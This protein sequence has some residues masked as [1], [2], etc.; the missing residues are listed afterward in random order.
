MRESQVD[1][2]VLTAI[3]LEYDAVRKVH[4]GAVESSM[5]EE[6]VGPANLLVSLRDFKAR[7]GGVLRVAVTYALEMG[8]VAA[9]NAAAPLMREYNP[10]CIA[11]SGV[12]AGRRGKVELGDVLI[13]DQLWQYDAGKRVAELDDRGQSTE[14]FFA[15]TLTYQLDPG[16]KQRAEAFQ[17]PRNSHWLQERP[18][19]V[20]SQADWILERLRRGENPKQHPER[21]EKC[22]HPDAAM[23]RLWAKGLLLPNTLELTAAGRERAEKLDSQHWSGLPNQPQFKVHVGPIGTGTQVVEDPGIFGRLST[24]MRDVLG[25]E[26]EAAAIGAVAHQHGM[27]HLVMKGVMDFAD[28]DKDDQFK[29]FAA[30]ASAECLLAFL[31]E[32]LQEERRDDFLRRLLERA[33]RASDAGD[34]AEAERLSRQA[35]DLVSATTTPE[36]AWEAWQT[37]WIVASDLALMGSGDVQ[38]LEHLLGHLEEIADRHPENYRVQVAT[39]MHRAAW[40]M[41]SGQFPIAD[42]ALEHARRLADESGSADLRELALIQSGR[43]YARSHLVDKLRD[44]I[45]SGESIRTKVGPWADLDASLAMMSGEPERAETAFWKAIR[46]TS[47]GRLVYEAYTHRCNAA[48]YM[49]GRRMHDRAVQ[50]CEF[51][52]E[53]GRL[54]SDHQLSIRLSLA[55]AVSRLAIGNST[56]A[57]TIFL[58]I[59]EQTQS[60][61]PYFHGMAQFGLADISIDRGGLAAARERAA[62]ARRALLAANAVD[63][64]ARVTGLMAYSW[65]SESPATAEDVYDEAIRLAESMGHPGRRLAASLRVDLVS[66]AQFASRDSEE[67]VKLVDEA[68]RLEELA[69]TEIERLE[70][71][72]RI[73]VASS[74]VAR[75]IRAFAET[76]EGLRPADSADLSGEV[77]RRLDPLLTWA[78]CYPATPIPEAL[79][80]AWGRGSFSALVADLRHDSLATKFT[81]GVASAEEVRRAVRML[82]P[83]ADCLVLIWRGA[84]DSRFEGNLWVPAPWLEV[85]G[86]PSGHGYGIWRD[87]DTDASEEV[88]KVSAKTVGPDGI[89]APY[90][91]VDGG[92]LRRVSPLSSARDIG[93][94]AAQGR[95]ASYGEDEV[96]W[97]RAGGYG[98]Y[99]PRDVAE[100]FLVELRP[101]VEIGRVILLPGDLVGCPAVDHDFFERSFHAVIG[102]CAVDGVSAT[103]YRGKGSEVNLLAPWFPEIEWRDLASLIVD[104]QDSLDELRS[105]IWQYSRTVSESGPDGVEAAS[106]EFR[107]RARS[108]LA[109]VQ[110]RFRQLE[111]KLSASVGP[112]IE[113]ELKG[114]APPPIGAERVW[115]DPLAP[116]VGAISELARLAGD[117]PW[118]WMWRARGFSSRVD[119]AKLGIRRPSGSRPHTLDDKATRER[120][121]A[122]W[123]VPANAGWGIR[124]MLRVPLSFDDDSAGGSQIVIGDRHRA[125]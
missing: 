80:D 14:R 15:K 104:E 27:R 21:E 107:E 43:H 93:L 37:R 70:V 111:S 3:R 20:A 64:A 122:H 123:L 12:C 96:P 57:E 87:M 33:E 106:R 94:L 25:L 82:A 116:A 19:P 118:Y 112:L 9:V 54:P 84:L 113:T 115:N 114:T 42:D 86:P 69:P 30:R 1:V 67:L 22:P 83:L 17:P 10:Q 2:L 63:M 72:R 124:R 48:E 16:W 34:Y 28:G 8:G 35:T 109:R 40:A 73:A 39:R 85:D 18:R 59:A 5:W 102:A 117:S 92:E 120:A 6:H 76:S 31:R 56:A 24:V 4:E 89:V 46:A 23:K 26:M 51:S 47:T 78:R 36:L 75:T 11:M 32:N 98:N 44:V 53:E 95:K 29:E 110:R 45:E 49:Q 52:P 99:L 13:A 7:H 74:H 100:L 61:L 55:E 119:V 38:H 90:R 88:K 77:A 68:R 105:V 71:V 65:L 62:A 81:V 79:I 97:L 50:F 103:G 108:G 125:E 121:D 60:R 58:R 91:R 66:H 101:L 41:E